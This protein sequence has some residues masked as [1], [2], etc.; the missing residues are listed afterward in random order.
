MLFETFSPW[1]HVLE[2]L[3]GRLKTIFLVYIDKHVSVAIMQS[4]KNNHLL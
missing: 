3:L 1:K 2:T 4:I